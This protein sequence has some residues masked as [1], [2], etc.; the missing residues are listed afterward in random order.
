MYLC[1]GEHPEARNY[2]LRNL[3][4]GEIIPHCIWADDEKGN[5]CVHR[6]DS[7]GNIVL[8]KEKNETEKDILHGNIKLEEKKW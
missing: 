6:Q 8:T 2:Q 4:T 5:Y 3:D 1:I 7:D